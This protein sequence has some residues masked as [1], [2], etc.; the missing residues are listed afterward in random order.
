M[1]LDLSLVFWV[2]AV[3]ATILGRSFTRILPVSGREADAA[4]SSGLR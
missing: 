4:D 2:Q 1:F 3:L